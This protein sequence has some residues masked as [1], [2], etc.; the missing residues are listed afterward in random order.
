[1]LEILSNVTTQGY[2][3]LHPLELSMDVRFGRSTLYHF[4]SFHYY[5]ALSMNM[6]DHYNI[7]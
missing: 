6:K 2:L 3:K 7:Q 1:M 5:F 4:E